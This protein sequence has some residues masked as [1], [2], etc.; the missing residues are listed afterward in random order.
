MSG[1]ESSFE[2]HN[3]VARGGVKHIFAGSLKD[4]VHSQAVAK[5][6]YFLVTKEMISVASASR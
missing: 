5:C 6:W 4:G 2:L 1:Y 3:G